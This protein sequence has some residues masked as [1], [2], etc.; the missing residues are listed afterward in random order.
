M[1]ARTATRTSS[2]TL[3]ASASP[4]PAVKKA[5]AP[6]KAGSVKKTASRKKTAA[7]SDASEAPTPGNKVE[8]LKKGDLVKVVASRTGLTQ[9]V[10]E[11]VL[12]AVLSGIQEAV[13][14]GKKV[15]LPSFGVFSARARSARKGRNP[16]TGEEIQIPASISPGFSPSKTWKDFLNEK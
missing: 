13:K 4:Q 10:S 8:T 1:P 16:Q 9:K 3:S 6:K 12:S 14:D 11:D 2:R 5:A 15:S 7:K